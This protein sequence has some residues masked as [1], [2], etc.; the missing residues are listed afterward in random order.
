MAD[1]LAGRSQFLQDRIMAEEKRIG[2]RSIKAKE[3]EA[4]G[5]SEA[6]DF[7]MKKFKEKILYNFIPSEIP[8]GPSPHAAQ[9]EFR[10][11]RFFENF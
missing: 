9:N 4:R 8:S 2:K 7:A 11:T 5:P 3:E 6:K 1:I 10:R